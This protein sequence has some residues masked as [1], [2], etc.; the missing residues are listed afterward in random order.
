M[1]ET[2]YD[3]LASGHQLKV[4]EY[5]C[6]YRD[7]L[8]QREVERLFYVDGFLLDADDP[9]IAT[10]DDLLGNPA[11]LVNPLERFNWMT[12]AT[13]HIAGRRLPPVKEKTE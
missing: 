2:L 9:L 13:Y 1:A 10:F 11:L 8:E 7:C 6:E 3:L 5:L 4:E 12:S